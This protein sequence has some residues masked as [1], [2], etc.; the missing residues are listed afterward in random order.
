MFLVVAGRGP[1]LEVDVP[2]VW[3]GRRSEA[4]SLII[5]TII[6]FGVKSAVNRS[7][8]SY[9]REPFKSIDPTDT[10]KGGSP[11]ASWLPSKPESPSRVARRMVSSGSVVL[12]DPHYQGNEFS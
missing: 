2:A 3:D 6:D 11:P 4:L 8:P 1:L 12:V 7:T 9:Y 5:G 10:N